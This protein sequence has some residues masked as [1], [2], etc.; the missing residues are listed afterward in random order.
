MLLQV[1]VR[2]RSKNTR[3]G[4]G[5]RT[6]ARDVRVNG[7][8]KF[9]SSPCG[10]SASFCRADLVKSRSALRSRAKEP[11]IGSAV[12]SRS[13]LRSRAKGAQRARERSR[14][15]LKADC[16]LAA[17]S[18][19]F[20]SVTDFTRGI[21]G[22]RNRLGFW[23]AKNPRVPAQ[24]WD[25]KTEKTY[26]AQHAS[27]CLLCRRVRYF[28]PF[29][30]AH[31]RSG[32]QV[33][34]TSSSA[35]LHRERANKVFGKRSARLLKRFHIA[36]LYVLVTTARLPPRQWGATRHCQARGGADRRRRLLCVVIP[37]GLETT[38]FC[39]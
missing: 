35:I 4:F 9:G 1:W 14:N 3:L 38:V 34:E 16:S 20:E 12:K 33:S 32:E 31:R 7:P 22:T 17:S 27:T 26:N 39:P 36:V 28:I 21:F 2:G 23:D 15:R 19:H 13:V 29:V 18:C 8:P 11:M 24:N 10:H 37:V 25:E 6:R 30:S 5:R